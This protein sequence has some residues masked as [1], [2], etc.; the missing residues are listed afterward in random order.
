MHLVED[1]KRQDGGKEGKHEGNLR[2]LSAIGSRGL[3]STGTSGLHR[4]SS[5]LVC[6]SDRRWVFS[7]W[8]RLLLGK[9]NPTP[10][11]QVAL[12]VRQRGP[13]LR[14]LWDRERCLHE[15]AGLH[16]DALCWLCTF[17]EHGQ[18]PTAPSPENSPELIGAISLDV[19]GSLQSMAS[20]NGDSLP[21]GKPTCG[22]IYALESSLWIRP[23][24]HFP[25]GHILLPY[26]M[27][28]QHLLLIQT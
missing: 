4:M 24:T 17:C 6:L 11:S 20:W 8:L 16:P 23:R 5:R 19:E 25:W 1:F 12:V 15:Y 9:V 3:S 10:T 13:L 7:C 14:R 26:L 21:P 2:M 18:L 27:K 28:S 22:A